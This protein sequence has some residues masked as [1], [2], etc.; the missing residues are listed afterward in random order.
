MSG[1]DPLRSRLDE[2]D[3]QLLA[4]LGERFAVCREIAAFKS[5]HDIA[6][7]QPRRVE[8]V[9]ARYVTGGAQAGM[10]DGFANA[11][12]E[13]LIDATCRMEDQLIAAAS[14]RTTA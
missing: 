9:R 10:P 7:M 2:I 5:A 6:M 1:L 3:V 12:F 11:L 4:L 8:E 14:D 13:L